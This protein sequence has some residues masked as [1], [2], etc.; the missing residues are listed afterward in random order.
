MGDDSGLIPTLK[1]GAGNVHLDDPRLLLYYIQHCCDIIRGGGQEARHARRQ[2]AAAKMIS[3][4]RFSG[5][6]EIDA[7]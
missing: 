1:L 4:A 3:L 7:F 6:I 5:Q 2:M